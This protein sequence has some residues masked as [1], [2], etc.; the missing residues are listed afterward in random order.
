VFGIGR[1][2]DLHDIEAHAEDGDAL[3][4]DELEC[5]LGLK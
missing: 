5:A 1:V 2:E 4:L 3:T